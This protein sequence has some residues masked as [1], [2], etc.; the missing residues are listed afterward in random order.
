MWKGVAVYVGESVWLWGGCALCLSHIPPPM[1]A[2]GG[3]SSKWQAL[4]ALT[5]LNS[6]VPGS[7][8][9]QPLPGAVCSG[10]ERPGW[11]ASMVQGS[12]Y[13][14][15]SSRDPARVMCCGGGAPHNGASGLDLLL[16]SLFSK[17]GLG[18]SHC[19]PCHFQWSPRSS[20]RWQ[21][22]AKAHTR[23][24]PDSVRDLGAGCEPWG[25]LTNGTR[26]NQALHL[27]SP[28]GTGLVLPPCCCFPPPSGAS[29]PTAE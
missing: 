27:H 4:R 1:A 17:A 28:A 2:G 6:G 8:W 13:I 21:G 9:L 10:K 23:L 19:T 7:M 22:V 12:P 20:T 11:P 29:L 26:P 14:T 5:A 15:C 3:G 25:A 16:T 24:P 18:A